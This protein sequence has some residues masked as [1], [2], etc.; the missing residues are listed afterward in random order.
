MAKSI[1]FRVVLT[2]PR[3]IIEGMVIECADH[4]K[5]K[6]TKI[7]SVKFIDMRTIVVIGLCR[8]IEE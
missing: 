2:I 7:K 6:V 1:P 8:N 5:A 3:D 4:S